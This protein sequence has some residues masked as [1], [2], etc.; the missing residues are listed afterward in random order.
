M[1]RGLRV[2]AAV[3][4]SV[5]AAAGLVTTAVASS[6]SSAVPTEHIVGL[7]NNPTKN[8]VAVVI[9]NGP[10]HAHGKDVVVNGHTDRFVFP[11][12]SI[13][14]KHRNTTKAHRHFDPVT[15]YSTFQQSGVY[16]VIG[17][18]GAYSG[19]SGHGKF[20][21]RGAAWGCSRHKPPRI[22]Q[23]TLHAAGPLSV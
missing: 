7:Q 3:G 17:G 13:T 12:G 8:G 15:C 23:L 6:A 18:T 1:V 14:V 4:V 11:K 5:L 22:F 9:G 20:I 10:I 19:A 2:W 16:R 21:V